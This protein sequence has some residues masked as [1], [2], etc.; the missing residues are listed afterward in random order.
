MA[1]QNVTIPAKQKLGHE[2]RNLVKQEDIVQAINTNDYDL[3]RAN[4]DKI[5]PWIVE[6]VHRSDAD[7]GWPLHREN[8]HL[9]EHFLK[10]GPDG[11]F[12][13]EPF[14]H[15]LTADRQLGWER[16]IK[17]IVKFDLQ[18]SEWRKVVVA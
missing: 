3:A 12:F 7:Y 9:F 10:D 5:K 13:E 18:R 8:L 4:F 2:L 6:H 15:W 11:W 16:F 17:T 1:N 14:S